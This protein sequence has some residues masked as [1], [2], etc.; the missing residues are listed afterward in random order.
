VSQQ[1]QDPTA[2]EHL[3]AQEH[4]TFVPPVPAS[5]TN[6]LKD[7]AEKKEYPPSFQLRHYSAKTLPPP[8]LQWCFDLVKSTLH[9]LYLVGVRLW[10]WG[11][12]ERV[13]Q[14]E[15]LKEAVTGRSPLLYTARC[16]HTRV[17]KADRHHA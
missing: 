12:E 9:H 6:A 5:D 10:V 11:L 4:L 1:I 16:A 17:S 13:S 8:L 2:P 15:T 7:V 14:L 3:T